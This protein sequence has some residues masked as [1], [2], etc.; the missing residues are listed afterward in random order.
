MNNFVTTI[1]PVSSQRM[2]ILVDNRLGIV[3]NSCRLIII[4]S[5]H[6]DITIVDDK[7]CTDVPLPG[8]EKEDARIL[9]K[10][11]SEN[12]FIIKIL[13]WI[14]V[15]LEFLLIYCSTMPRP[16]PCG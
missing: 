12:R 6:P 13:D 10:R 14:Q 5:R 1:T 3:T 2:T 4:L 11:N 8:D 16:S 15:L 9:Q 7:S